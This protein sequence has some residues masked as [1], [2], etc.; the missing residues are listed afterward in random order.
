MRFTV[1]AG[2]LSAALRGPADR[3]RSTSVIPIL[4][5][6]KVTADA[7]DLTLLGHDLDS[8]TVSVMP[9]EVAM[10]GS[11]AI[12]AEP[13]VKL[14][15]GLPKPAHVTFELG[16]R[17]VVIKS[18]RSR[19]KLP[20]LDAGDMPGPLTADG[21][22]RATVTSADLEQ[23]FE[24]PRAA[25]NMKHDRLF[26]RGM[27]LH[28]V[29]GKL[30]SVAADGHTLMRFSTDIEA[31]GFAGAIVPRQAADEILKRGAGELAISGRI[32]S[33]TAGGITYAS[34][35]IDSIFPPSYAR[36]IPGLDG[37]KATID[38]EALLESLGRLT[39]IGN[40]IEENLIDIDVGR[41]E[42]SISIAGHADGR[43]TIE[44]DATED[45]FV[46]LRVDQFMEAVKAMKGEQVELRITK[47]NMPV[48]VSDASE[49]DAVNVLMPCISKNRQA[50]AA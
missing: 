31:K 32:V 6:I 30:A 45:L 34:K 29:D 22:F 9:A 38:R 11:C 13:L 39:T 36:M 18:G 50:I 49:P 37:A 12:P 1:V 4:K 17:V 33:I 27:F 10:A 5:H 48:R 8:S 7:A 28:D 23:L 16:D 14:V 26:C 43:E 42:V 20:V 35:L 44:C 41:D 3:A 47:P 24:R 25:I 46:C 15:N 40:Y 19:Y 2:E 21:G